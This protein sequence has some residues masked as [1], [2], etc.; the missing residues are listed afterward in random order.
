MRSTESTYCHEELENL[1][2]A[3]L[4]AFAIP[5]SFHKVLRDSRK[6]RKLSA[7]STTAA[8][9]RVAQAYRYTPSI[10]NIQLERSVLLAI[11]LMFITVIT[12]VES[13]TDPTKTLHG[14]ENVIPCVHSITSY[15]TCRKV[16]CSFTVKLKSG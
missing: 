11:Y 13:L 9:I 3:P 5:V 4:R 7:F 1:S 15:V 2:I 8:C 14:L 6:A 16:Q 10:V 12:D